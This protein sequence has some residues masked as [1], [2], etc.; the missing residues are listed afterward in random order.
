MRLSSGL[1]IKCSVPIICAYLYSNSSLH[2]LEATVHLLYALPRTMTYAYDHCL[3]LHKAIVLLIFTATLQLSADTQQASINDAVIKV[4]L[5][6]TDWI[7]FTNNGQ[8][9]FGGERYVRERNAV[10]EL[11]VG[12]FLY[13]HLNH[14]C[15]IIEFTFQSVF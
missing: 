5:Y 1:S 14:Y 13:L 4:H 6:F 3:N 10:A 15:C 11:K 12:Y 9:M 8:D 7:S 2:M